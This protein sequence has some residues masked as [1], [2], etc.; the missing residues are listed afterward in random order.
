MHPP[1]LTTLWNS[2]ANL[3]SPAAWDS[4]LS[5]IRTR[6]HRRRRLFLG[7]LI[8]ASFWT[9]LL[10]IIVGARWWN[11]Q[12]AALRREWSAPFLLAMQTA[13]VAWFWML[14]FKKSDRA[15]AVAGKDLRT[16]LGILLTENR[17]T[18]L[19]QKIIGTLLLITAAAMPAVVSQLQAAGK[20][21]REIQV[22]FLLGMPLIAV[23]VILAM[24]W[25]Y[26]KVLAPEGRALN[27]Q[28]A[29]IREPGITAV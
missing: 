13:A 23:L 16:G 28:L 20:A 19:R 15:P 21:G 26:L 29:E 24:V 27:E 7:V 10:I 25:H 11:G 3:P 14:H 8:S 18:C 2:P 17:R 22:P 9:I 6:Q 4:L 12:G 5:T 1:D